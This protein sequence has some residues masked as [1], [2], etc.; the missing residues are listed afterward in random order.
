[1]FMLSVML[2]VMTFFQKYPRSSRAV[3]PKLGEI[4]KRYKGIYNIVDGYWR[5]IVSSKLEKS[6]WLREI[7]VIYCILKN[8]KNPLSTPLFS[9]TSLQSNGV[10]F[11][12]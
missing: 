5:L 10:F 2:S 8:T 1:M 11:T 3:A 7:T 12:D 9:Y 4:Y 6:N